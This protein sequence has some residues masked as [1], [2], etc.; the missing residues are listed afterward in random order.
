MKKPTGTFVGLSTIDVI[1]DLPT[2]PTED[3]KNAAL[4]HVICAGGPASNAAVSFAYLGGRARLVSALG[5]SSLGRLAKK[6]LSLHGVEHFDLSPGLEANPTISSI[7]VSG[8]NGARTIVTS[9]ATDCVAY[10]NDLG[11]GSYNEIDIFLFDGYESDLAILTAK[12]AREFGKIT[13][14]DGDIY[15]QNLEKLLC[16]IDI[17]IFGQ[18]FFVEGRQSILDIRDYCSRFGISML[19]GT[20]GEHPIEFIE[21]NV[22]G[23]IPVMRRKVVDTLGAGDIFHGAFC[24][25]YACGESFSKALSLASK[26]ASASVSSFGTRE[27]TSKFKRIDFT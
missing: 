8:N 11:C 27:W 7:I 1:F 4:R 21:R 19:A 22:V 10:V 13:V 5:A 20:H 15:R 14:L 2:F 3:S 23:E 25:Y 16:Y 18:S 12:H 17:V 9:K 24:Y 26:V 6:D